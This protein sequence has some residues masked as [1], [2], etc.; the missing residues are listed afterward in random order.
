MTKEEAKNHLLEE[1]KKD[2]IDDESKLIK[3]S[4]ENIKEKIS[5]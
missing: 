1:V 4:E 3:Q 5:I 2:I